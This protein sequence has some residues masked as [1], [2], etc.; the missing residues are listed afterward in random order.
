MRNIK[1]Y[2]KISLWTVVI[3]VLLL[4]AYETFMLV[5]VS[6]PG[7]LMKFPRRIKN[8]I[9]NIYAQERKIIQ[10]MPECA[11]YD[12]KISYRLRPGQCTFSGKEFSTRYMI[13][14][15]GMRDDESSL[16]HPEIVVAG[17]SFAM[18][19]G[20]GQEQTFAQII[21][22]RS[23]M[24]VLN[25]AIASYGTVR[26]MKILRDVP[27][28]RLKYLIIQYCENDLEENREFYLNGDRLPIMSSETYHH[29]VELH[30]KSRKYFFGRYVLLKLKKRIDEFKQRHLN[31]NTVS[32][33][34]AGTSS[35]APRD[36]IDL[37]I[38]AIVKSRLNLTHVRI[39]AFVMN[40]R[41]PDD[42]KSF[43]KLLKERIKTG[44]YP[45]FIKHMIVLD[46]SDALKEDD[47]FIL[48]DHLNAAG[49][50]VIAEKLLSV[51]DLGNK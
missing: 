45:D 20:V 15:L 4:S 50:E 16:D 44:D 5:L 10:Y 6:H 28:D 31:T 49:H 29:L 51:M 12:P 42:N 41:N 38:N 30:Q 36:K 43:P 40:G 34:N 19:W 8:S 14:R 7:L 35:R 2:I 3:F 22:R 39:I 25:S 17:D 46:L 23:G 37:F 24:K 9:R 26:E 18:G 21:E 47:F 32:P 33:A 27:L 13:N 11:Q 1:E 48:D